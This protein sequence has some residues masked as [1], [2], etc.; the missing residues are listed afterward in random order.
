MLP[1][2]ALAFLPLPIHVPVLLRM[3]V[4]WEVMRA[5]RLILAPVASRPSR[6]N[7][8]RAPPPVCRT[9]TSPPVRLNH[10][11]SVFGIANRNYSII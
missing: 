4:D 11:I 7:T 2:S 8:E 9:P 3:E 5:D 10:N 1:R 6:Q